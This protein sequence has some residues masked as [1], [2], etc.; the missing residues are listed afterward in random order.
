MIFM[1]RATKFYEPF[2]LAQDRGPTRQKNNRS[3]SL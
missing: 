2:E 3:V 1:A